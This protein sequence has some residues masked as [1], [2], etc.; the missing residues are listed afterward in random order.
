VAA[1]DAHRLGILKRDSEGRI[2][3]FAEKPKDPA[4]QAGLISRNDP[5]RPFLGSMGI[6]MFKTEALKDILSRFTFEDFGNHVIPHA[7]G[8]HAVYGFDFNDYWVD[9]GT[10]RTFYDT[11][12]ALAK[13]NPPF[14]LFDPQHPIYTHARFLPGSRIDNSQLNNVLMAEGCCIQRSEIDTA[15]IGLRSQID[16]GVK[17]KDSVLMGSDYYDFSAPMPDRRSDHR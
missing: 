12:L 9:I 8:T 7:I 11:N 1:Q 5:A 16:E 17:I 14:N 6:Y 4:V 15:V 10:M 2:T 3:A 13:P